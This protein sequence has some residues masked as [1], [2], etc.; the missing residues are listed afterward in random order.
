MIDIKSL[1][2]AIAL[3]DM[4]V[5]ASNLGMLHLPQID[6]AKIDRSLV[7]KAECDQ[8]KQTVIEK[9]IEMC[10][11]LGICCIAE[12]IETRQQADLLAG[13]ECDSL[14]GYYIGKPLSV[15]EFFERSIAR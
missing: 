14:Q 7:F 13:F 5:E 8:R 3:D 6:F 15:N 4:G 10:H 1:G 9:L 12:G 2:I 11:R